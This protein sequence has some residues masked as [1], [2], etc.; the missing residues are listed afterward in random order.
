MV[1][2][3][4]LQTSPE[5]MIKSFQVAVVGPVLL[6]QAAY[7]HMPRN[8]RIINIGSVASKMGFHQM[9]VYGAVKAAMDQLT[10]TLA[11]EVRIPL[12]VFVAKSKGHGSTMID[13]PN[14]LTMYRSVVM[15][16]ASRSTQL[17][18]AQH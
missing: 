6:L 13:D 16:R 18:R 14:L 12:L 15:A 7:S 10:W 3:G 9:A 5:D 1:P 11:Q 8:G 4:A 2:G 17:R